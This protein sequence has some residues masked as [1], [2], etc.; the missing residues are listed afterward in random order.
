MVMITIGVA[1]LAAFLVFKFGFVGLVVM[2][3]SIFWVLNAG[4]CSGPTPFRKAY[5]ETRA[6]HKARL[7]DEDPDIGRTKNEHGLNVP[8][9]QGQFGGPGDNSKL[10]HSRGL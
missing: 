1:L 10:A 7:N 6:V 2:A 5:C 8:D 9:I 4:G 3:I